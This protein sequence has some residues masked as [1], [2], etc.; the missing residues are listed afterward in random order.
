MFK[1]WKMYKAVIFLLLSCSNAY[2]ID[3]SNWKMSK[4]EL[5]IHAIHIADVA[6]THASTTNPVF[7]ENDPITRKII[8]EYPTKER[9][10]L[11]GIGS[12]IANHYII[13]GIESSNMNPVL[14]KSLT[15]GYFIFKSVAVH[16]NNRIGVR[17]SSNH[18]A[19]MHH[20]R[21][22]CRG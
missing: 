1:G 12:A 18:K 20:T 22:K 11:W 10:L 3:M 9:V 4:T 7:C 6:Q 19:E 21:V 8:G 13:S 5:A 2:A 16:E 14:K 17:I 15:I